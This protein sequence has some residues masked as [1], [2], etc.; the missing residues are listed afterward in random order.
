V[1]AN[2]V[3]NTKNANHA[4]HCPNEKNNAENE[5][6]ESELQLLGTVRSRAFNGDWI[7]TQPGSVTVSALIICGLFD[8]GEGLGCERI[9]LFHERDYRTE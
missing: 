9:L 6:A 2:D 1:K 8:A 3:V 5:G 7:T 4:N